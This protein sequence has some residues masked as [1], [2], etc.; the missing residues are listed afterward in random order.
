MPIRFPG[1]DM[2]LLVTQAA[3]HTRLYLNCLEGLDDSRALWRAEGR[4]NN[5]LFVAAHLVDS[6]TWTAGILGLDIPA[7]FGGALK[8]GTS[9]EDL[10]ELP[11]LEEV[12]DEWKAVSALL[13][14]SL[15]VVTPEELGTPSTTRFPVSDHSLAGSLAF[16]LHHEAY[17]IGQLALLRRA[18]GLPAMLY[19]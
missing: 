7:P 18:V 2:S 10:P 16:L 17:H 6:R 11:D 4:S 19:R 8:Y 13:E 3:L 12:I 14:A 5:I 15:A 9:I 1:A